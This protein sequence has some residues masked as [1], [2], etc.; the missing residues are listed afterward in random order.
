LLSPPYLVIASREN[1]E[2]EEK[3]RSY[4]SQIDGRV[5]E[6]RIRYFFTSV[7]PTM[8]LRKVLDAYRQVSERV[9]IVR[10]FDRTLSKT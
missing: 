3:S 2:R 4:C 5:T 6:R 9:K 8:T 7:A 1:E 10:R